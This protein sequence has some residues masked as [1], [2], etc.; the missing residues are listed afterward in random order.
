[1][2]KHTVYIAIKEAPF[3]SLA[4]TYALLFLG[5]AIWGFQPILVKDLVHYW[6]PA[7]IIS[8][9]WA[10][11]GFLM[12]FYLHF[13]DRSHFWPWKKDWPVLMFM[14]L[15]GIMGNSLLQFT[16]LRYT[17]VTNSTLITA[18]TPAIT[19]LIACIFLK[20][21]LGAKSWLGIVLAFAGVL[22]IITEADV[23]VLLHLQFNYGDILC[24]ISQAAWALYTLASKRLMDHM[25]IMGVL[26]WASVFGS[27]FTF[28][29]GIITGEFQ[30]VPL[31]TPQFLGF[32]YMILMGGI[33]ANLCWNVGVK[34]AGPSHTAV[35]LN[36]AP[37]V[38]ML[39]GHIIY[40]D[41]LGPVQILGA[42][43]IF[44]GVY[45]TNHGK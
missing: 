25:N 7:T 26:G 6:N 16:G 31:P 17:M 12:L 15:T 8:F 11:V 10:G 13:R 1:M 9:R 41:P 24:F 20:E 43:V 5:S 39:C 30:P 23:D 4:S 18:T 32:L 29:F 44:V 19:A 27:L 21:R 37:I 22:V 34:N 33:A 45:L 42:A 28:I 38:G 14:G 2:I 35:F 36:V 40:Y 3:M